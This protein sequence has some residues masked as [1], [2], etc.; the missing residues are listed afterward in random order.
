MLNRT[1]QSIKFHSLCLRC[2][3]L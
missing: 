3:K 1:R 2:T